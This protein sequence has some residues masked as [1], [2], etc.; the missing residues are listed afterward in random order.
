MVEERV[1][2][3]WYSGM[4][5]TEDWWAV[6][7]GLL[8]VGLGLFSLA[9]TDLVGWV[10]SP[11]K[12]GGSVP[13]G[14]GIVVKGEFWQ[15]L[16]PV[17]SFIVT[18]IIFTVLV[19]IG[20]ACMKWNLSRFLAGWTIIY[21]L[22]WACWYIGH[23]AHL[24]AMSNKLDDFDIEWSL[25]MGGGASYLLALV[26]GLLIGN[27]AQGLARFLKDA[28]KPEWFIKTAIVFLGVKLG[29]KSMEA[30]GY[31]FDV[32]ITGAA[33]T[34]VAYT[35]FW[36]IVYTM[37]RRGFK[38]SRQ[39]AAC[40]ASGVSICGVSATVATGGAIRAKTFIP[41]VVSILV[42]VCTIFMIVGLPPM[43]SSLLMNEPLV[44]G[45]AVGMTVKT[46]GGEAATGAIL[47]EMMWAEAHE[48]A[49]TDPANAQR[50]D[51][52]EGWILSVAIITKIW[53]DMF[54]GIWAFV[55]AIIW[56]NKVEKKP[57]QARIPASE[58]WFRFP[59]F[60]IGYVI[61][62]LVYVVIGVGAGGSEAVIT[63]A[64][65]GAEP[66]EGIIRRL[67]FMLTF[68]SIGVI[69]DFRRLK[70]IGRP[71]LVYALAQFII[72]P[73]IA[74]LIA[75]IFHNGMMPPPPA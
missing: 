60:V 54:I 53:I 50:W 6:W 7:I 47:E 15:F 42:V 18:Y 43:Y 19:T 2:K 8:I 55:L 61:A 22:T 3:K 14:D 46:D 29:V 35:L 58:I 69:T 33:A 25:N 73:P 40:L 9:G 41:V 68:M 11:A 16:T 5:S 71:A 64:E 23:N 39:W 26:V 4:L 24:A 65:T 12:W 59:K 20:A 13:A 49:Q 62:W 56:V 74:L 75:W 27:F 21:L 44:A 51:W 70:G 38:M 67:F 34:V 66:V 37:A 36:P 52:D 30:G 17:G 31:A 72:I 32:A 48:R 57:G 63:A 1:N 28:A 10:A 45:S